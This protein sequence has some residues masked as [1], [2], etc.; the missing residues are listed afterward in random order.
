MQTDDSLFNFPCEFPIKAMGETGGDFK[1]LVARL[2][3]KHYPELPDEAVRARL[4]QGGRYMSVTVTVVAHSRS[5]LDDIYME[6]TAE[7][8]VLIAL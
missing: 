3:R 7:E 5:Q 6:L 8:R 4:S 1:D 2:V